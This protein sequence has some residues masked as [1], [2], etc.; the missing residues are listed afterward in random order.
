MPGRCVALLSGGL[1]S[2]LAIRIMQ[3][4]G[5]EV[6]ALS[7]STIFTCC[8]DAAGQAARTLGIRLTMMTQEDDYLDLV[9][10]PQ[11]GYGKGANPC[12]DCRIY[13]F[14]RARTFMEQVSA[15]FVVSGEVVGQRPMSQKRRDL[16]IIAHHA[17]LDD[18]LLRPLSARLLPPTAAERTGLVDRERLYAFSGRS[19]KELISLARNFDFPDIPSPS[20]GC[21][22]TEQLFAKKV[23]DLVLLDSNNTRWDFELL[24]NGRHFRYDERTKVVVGK[25]ESDNQMLRYRHQLPEGR[26]SLLLTPENF[27]GPVVLLI[28]PAVD[29]A[30]RFA[31]GLLL[32]YTRKYNPD[33]ARLRIHRHGAG[34]SAVRRFTRLPAAQQAHPLAAASR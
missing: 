1:D 32:R 5:V 3:E 12:V 25:N 13:M 29:H 33:D 8:Q 23:H 11:F 21:A 9:R 22:L 4:Q 16:D 28:G 14:Q 6:E 17:G 7:F 10:R 24:K 26:S 18:R 27:A 15:Q 34:N 19:R 2:M 30:V 31:G 20:N